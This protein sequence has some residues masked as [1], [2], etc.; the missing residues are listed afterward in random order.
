MDPF[1]SVWTSTT[2]VFLSKQ[3]T[4]SSLVY[5]NNAMLKVNKIFC[6]L[7]ACTFFVLC[8]RHLSKPSGKWTDAVPPPVDVHPS[9]SDSKRRLH[10]RGCNYVQP[11]HCN[12][13][14]PDLHP[15]APSCTRGQILEHCISV[16]R[17]V[18][19]FPPAWGKNQLWKDVGHFP[20]VCRGP[21]GRSPRDDQLYHG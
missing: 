14:S 10:L 9:S 16:W 4:S 11:V 6:W 2:L 8:V 12:H 17:R 19:V 21:Y 15:G 18:W 7:F 13:L 20:W 1:T 5:W 3:K